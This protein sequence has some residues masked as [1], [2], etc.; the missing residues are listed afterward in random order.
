MVDWCR[1]AGYEPAAHHQLIISALADVAAGDDDRVMIFM[2]PGSAKST[3]GSIL[4]PPWYMCQFPSH[5]VMGCSHTM[6]LA[7]RF[8]KRVRN[9]IMNH[10]EELGIRVSDDSGAADRW[11]LAPADSDEATE[12]GGEYMAAGV[13]TGIA[14]FRSDLTIIDDPVKSRQEAESPVIQLK[15]WDWWVFDVR[16]R[17]KPGGK[18]VLIM[19]RWSE[20]DLAG[21]LLAEE[22]D[23]ASGGRWRIINLPM[24]AESLDDP[25]GRSI[26]ERLWPEWFTDEMVA[27]AKR[28]V[29]LWMALYQ[30]RPTAEEGTYWK[31][32]WLNPVPSGHVPP[33]RAMRVYG[34][35]DYATKKDGGDFTVHLCIGLDPDDRPWL[36]DMWRKQTTSDY[37]VDA[38]CTMVKEMKPL[39]WAEER[40]Q[41]INSVGPFLDRE[42]RK[43][44]AY[45]ER[46]QFTSVADKGIMAQ[47]MRGQIATM[48]LWYDAE[49]P[50]RN[51]LE[52]ELLS[53]PSG[54]HDDIHDALGKCGM[55]LDTAVKGA[56]VVKP[57]AAQVSGYRTM[58]TTSAGGSMKVL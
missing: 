36:L 7:T 1:A 8:S 46:I 33:R 13:D 35:S 24:E 56:E 45:T 54:K 26:G 27:E 53:F 51:A 3:Y 21:R 41:I 50:W 23:K 4:F 43:Q 49:A 20:L 6:G 42:Q 5:N 9:I 40:G 30:Q 10:P 18:V 28:D 57:S 11:Q 58:K 12:E 15:V 29:R 37:W 39:Q 38:W 44:K 25:L 47:S 48:G 34:G 2:P 14:G 32:A 22:G 19:T 31:R 17:L 16:P 55:L 52:S